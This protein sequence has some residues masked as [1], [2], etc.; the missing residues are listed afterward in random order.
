M[1]AYCNKKNVCQFL[2]FFS[3][4]VNKKE[5]TQGDHYDSEI[6]LQ[7]KSTQSV[8]EWICEIYVIFGVWCGCCLT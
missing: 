6:H 4:T 1:Y 3:E 8:G 5:Y 7:K 2:F